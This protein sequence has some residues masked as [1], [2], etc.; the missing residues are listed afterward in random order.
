[1]QEE[2]GAKRKSSLFL[3]SLSSECTEEELYHIFAVY[4]EIFDIKIMK[5]NSVNKSLTYGFVNFITVKAATLAKKE[6]NGFV[7]HGEPLR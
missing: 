6:L 2:F 1:M 7:V 4:G 5:S 3:A